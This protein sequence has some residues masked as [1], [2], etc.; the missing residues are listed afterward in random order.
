MTYPC[1]ITVFSHGFPDGTLPKITAGPGQCLSWWA[2]RYGE[3][4]KI[5]K[6]WAICL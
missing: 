3:A 5:T 1:N 4:I 2:A 6:W